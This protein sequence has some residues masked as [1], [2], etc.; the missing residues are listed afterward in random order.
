[1]AEP[2]WLIRARAEIGQHEV[3][4]KTSNPRI[5]EYLASCGLARLPDETPWCGAFVNWCVRGSSGIDGP[6]NA[7]GAWLGAWAPAW[8]NWGERLETGIPGAVCVVQRR[9]AGADAAT[10][11]SSG[12]HVAFWLAQD[13]HFVQL[14]GG[15]QSDSVRISAFPLNSYDIRAIRWPKNVAR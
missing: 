9:Q 2:S 14:L 4:G 11:S 15:N 5:V 1:M 13:Q 6:R 12:M 8:A 3:A 7:A 10:G